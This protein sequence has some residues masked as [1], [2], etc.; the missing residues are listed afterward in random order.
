MSDKEKEEAENTATQAQLDAVRAEGHAAGVSD[1]RVRVS[2]ILGHAKAPVNFAQ[3]T[4]AVKTGLTLGQAT[5]VLDAMPEA[6]APKAT[7]IPGAAFAAQLAGLNP[8]V[9][10]DGGGD[11][12]PDEDAVAQRA[13]NLVNPLTIVGGK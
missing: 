5:G 2:G 11:A 1:E 8:D 12:E 4:N 13:A 7:T 10:A 9:A 3:A 6:A